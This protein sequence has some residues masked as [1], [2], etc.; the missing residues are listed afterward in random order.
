LYIEHDIRLVNGRLLL[1]LYVYKYACVVTCPR[2]CP[3]TS[4][5]CSTAASKQ[6]V[7][8]PSTSSHLY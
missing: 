8:L 3:W 5:A 6:S 2:R 7:K 1:P 4:A